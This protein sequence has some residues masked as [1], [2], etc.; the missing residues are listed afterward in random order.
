MLKVEKVDIEDVN[1]VINS[2]RQICNFGKGI[3]FQDLTKNI[4]DAFLFFVKYKKC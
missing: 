1:S 2:K 4:D 3:A